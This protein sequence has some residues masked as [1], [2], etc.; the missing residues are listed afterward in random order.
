[1]LGH[2]WILEVP[3]RRVS[4]VGYTHARVAYCTE[5]TDRVQGLNT[6]L[7]TYSLCDLPSEIASQS[8]GSML[9]RGDIWMIVGAECALASTYD[10]RIRISPH[11]YQK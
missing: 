8:L 4:N 11:L 1:M 6:V 10:F 5:L 3:L 9:G 7:I 2:G